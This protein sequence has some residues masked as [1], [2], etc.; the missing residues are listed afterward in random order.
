MGVKLKEV[1]SDGSHH[2]WL[3]VCPACKSVHQCDGRWGF[4]G[5]LEAPTFTG[6]VL[7]HPIPDIGRPLCHSHVTDG[8]ITYCSDST[9]G[10]AGQTLELPDWDFARGLGGAK[11]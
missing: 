2:S 7:V 11:S 5:N 1:L 6:S 4:N 3:W 8:K 9:H 10:Y